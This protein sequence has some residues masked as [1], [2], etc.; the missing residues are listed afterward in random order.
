MDIVF[1][2]PKCDVELAVDASGAG[3]AINC[4]E[5]GEPITIPVESTVAAAPA[6]IA[7]PPPPSPAPPPPPVAAAPGE[8][9]EE[10]LAHHAPINAIA[11]SAA[12]KIE[13]HFSVPVSNKPVQTLVTRAIKPIEE[14]AKGTKRIRVKT[15]RHSDCIEVGHDIFDQTVSNFVEKVGDANIVSI[16]PVNYSHTEHG[17][18]RLVS[19][20]GLI[21]IYKG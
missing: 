16:N 11:S 8:S 10:K 21:I 6:P 19:D 12:A 15:I 20:Y 17:G 1:N 9:V 5:C 7:P 14:S 18:D 13:H 3:S 2:C 4:P